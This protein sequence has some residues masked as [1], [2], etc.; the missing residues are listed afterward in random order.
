M[1]KKPSDF[2][3]GTV[4]PNNDPR[5]VRDRSLVEASLVLIILTLMIMLNLSPQSTFALLNLCFLPVTLAAF[6]LGGYRAANTTFL[7]VL[8]A[9]IAIWHRADLADWL[10]I[11]VWGGILGLECIMICTLRDDHHREVDRLLELHRT[12]TLSD[13]LT[14]V[15][16]RRAFEYEL[17]RRMSEWNR[18]RV[19][20]TLMLI[21]IDHFKR[22]NDTYGHQA[23]DVVLSSVAQRIACDCRETDLLAR[24]GGEEFGVVMPNTPVDEAM[25]LAERV[26]CGIESSRFE[27]GS[28][29][30][31]VT[32]SVGLAQILRGEECSTL[33]NR[34][35]SSLYT[36]KK[37]GRNCCH[38]HDGHQCKAFGA[39]AA[40]GSTQ[41][42]V[43]RPSPLASS[44][45]EVIMG[46]PTRRVFV[47]ELRQRLSEIRRYAVDLSLMLVQLDDVDG[48]DETDEDQRTA[49][50]DVVAQHIQYVVRDSDLVAYFDEDQFAVLMP[51][52]SQSKAL[53]P[54]V[55]LCQRVARSRKQIG[56][57]LPSQITVSVGL[58]GANPEDTGATLLQRSEESLWFAVRQGG[59]RVCITKEDGSDPTLLEANG[60]AESIRQ[61]EEFTIAEIRSL[62][63]ELGKSSV[64]QPF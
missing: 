13:A 52:T 7:C 10:L 31:K 58:T 24:Y 32:I 5:F 30:V 26:R 28:R 45:T 64:A 29:S 21:D 43:A 55:R 42:A 61:D 3:S 41:N 14:G 56:S 20:L 36:S 40:R 38:Y 17:D 39:V 22:L 6:F 33:V 18:Q 59:N 9:S 62:N 60:D 4:T 49:I 25:K 27:I 11:G 35:D 46:L 8:G 16:N 2:E 57:N 12:D 19:P 54:A 53:T 50:R 34:S 23:G 48:L 51:S 37:S 44:Y 63:A 15:A 1:Q 47:D